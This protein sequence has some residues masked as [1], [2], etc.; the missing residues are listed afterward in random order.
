LVT[1]KS[2]AEKLGLSSA[3]VS[4]TLHND[5]TLVITPETRLRVLQ[6]AE[7]MG[8]V[9]KTP[10]KNP[11]KSRSQNKKYIVVFHNRQIFRHQIDSSYY[12]AVR[13][14]IE[15]ACQKYGFQ[16]GFVD[17]ESLDEFKDQNKTDGAL[18][19]GNYPETHYKSIKE[20]LKSLPIVS[21]GIISYYPESID[22][23]THSNFEAVKIALEYLFKNGHTKIGY[24][25]VKEAPGTE[26]FGSRKQFFL[27]I[28]K[29]AGSCNPDWV[30]ETD[31][32]INRVD[33]GYQ[34]MKAWIN[35]KRP[36]PTA[37]FCANDPIALGSIKAL[38]EAAIPVPE[39]ISII[40][41]DGSFP[42]QYSFPAL[43]SVDV[44]P[45]Q[46]GIEGVNLLHER[47]IKGRKIAKTVLLHPELVV[48]ESVK[49]L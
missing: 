5:D 8:Y 31:R 35:R 20:K 42:A 48:R 23:I 39:K 40:S 32:G 19:V 41:H 38:L 3:T 18:I 12:F 33:Q 24:M 27:T 45:Y 25:G 22:H 14:G 49:K 2:I 44:H 7:E 29:E 46:L 15:D 10:K 4:R 6:M 28:M 11:V 37:I 16:Y 43:T 13:T 21:V 17:I 34:L 47:I 36:L 9:K 26:L 1:V 30:F